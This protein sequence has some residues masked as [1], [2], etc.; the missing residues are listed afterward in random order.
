MQ[1]RKKEQCPQSQNQ[2]WSLRVWARRGNVSRVTSNEGGGRDI[3]IDEGLEPSTQ[4]CLFQNILKTGP[5]KMLRNSRGPFD[6][7]GLVP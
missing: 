2:N 1:G 6:G 4:S 3:T 5:Q 7:G